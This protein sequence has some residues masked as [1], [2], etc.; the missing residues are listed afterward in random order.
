MTT[1]L[2]NR[3]ACQANTEHVFSLFY[4]IKQ[5]NPFVDE[6]ALMKMINKVTGWEYPLS[7]KNEYKNSVLSNLNLH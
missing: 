7:M 5:E 4:E 2:N 1:N 3:T 6:S